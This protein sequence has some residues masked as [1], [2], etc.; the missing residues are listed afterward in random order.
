MMK[1]LACRG[2]RQSE[3]KLVS[4][5]FSY[6][7]EANTLRHIAPS[8]QFVVPRDTAALVHS[9]SSGQ[10]RQDERALTSGAA[11]SRLFEKISEMTVYQQFEPDWFEESHVRVPTLSRAPAPPSPLLASSSLPQSSSPLQLDTPV[12]E[13]QCATADYDGGRG[14]GDSGVISDML[15]DGDS[16]RLKGGGDPGR[17]RLLV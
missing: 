3:N 5:S 1:Y 14:S 17:L 12:P 11:W 2:A 6:T 4:G 9:L 13:L 10:C 15:S 8:G 7:A 16:C